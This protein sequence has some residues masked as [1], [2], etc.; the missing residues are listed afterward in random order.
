MKTQNTKFILKLAV[1][2]F[3]FS[4]SAFADNIH[5]AARD[6]ELT[7]VQNFVQQGQLEKKDFHNNTALNMSAEYGHLDVVAFLLEFQAD[8][9]N[10]DGD[11]SNPLIESIE[12]GHI[13]VAE[14]L[15]P[16]TPLLITNKS[17]WTALHYAANAGYNSLVKTILDE[18]QSRSTIIIK[19]V[20]D[21][22]DPLQNTPL[23]LAA[24]HGFYRVVKYLVNS[25]A[26]VNSR[27]SMNQ[28]P[29]AEA[30]N[31]GHQK[32]ANFLRKN[33]ATK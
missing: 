26:N 27:N 17:G 13:N 7:K 1:A 24:K 21:N 19:Q 3:F 25:H 23:H 10:Q 8:T 33:G 9:S 14:Y 2:L 32:I 11:G 6:G 18:I 22:K 20:V 30:E 4:S 15:V 16:H 5:D 28:T 31:N 12:H 29:L